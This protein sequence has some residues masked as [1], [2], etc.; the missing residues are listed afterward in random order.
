M[1]GLGSKK[2]AKDT[3][4]D[5]TQVLSG[6][7]TADINISLPSNAYAGEPLLPVYLG[8]STN[9][10]SA[11]QEHDTKRFRHRLAPLSQ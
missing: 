2:R 6:C 7:S 8:I 3:S 1:Q 5:A 9:R 11:Q 4:I 10:L